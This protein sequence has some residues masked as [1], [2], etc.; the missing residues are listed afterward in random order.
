M[1]TPWRHDR[2]HIFANHDHVCYLFSFCL[3]SFDLDLT[4]GDSTNG[5]FSC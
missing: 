4:E 3:E 1:L 5:N 2:H